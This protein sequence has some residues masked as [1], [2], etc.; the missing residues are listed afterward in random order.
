MAILPFSAIQSR[1][2]SN[3]VSLVSLSL[4]S[5]LSLI[6]SLSLSLAPYSTTPISIESNQR[7]IKQMSTNA[8]PSSSLKKRE[9][10]YL[11]P[12]RYR[13]RLPLPPMPPVLLPINIPS[14]RYTHHNASNRLW[15]PP[16][17]IG[18]IVGGKNELT[19]GAKLTGEK[20][21]GHEA[22]V[23]YH[24]TTSMVL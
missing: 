4:S 1:V 9:T 24:G 14:K 17:M 2:Q 16:I 3:L 12:L 21:L 20:Q 13:N 23:R 11:L 10:G 6:D 19:A 8:P 15:I 18:P 5:A 22:L 7:R